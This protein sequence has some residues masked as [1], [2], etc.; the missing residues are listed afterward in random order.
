MIFKIFAAKSEVQSE[1][2]GTYA[3]G[4]F[5]SQRIDVS[6]RRDGRYRSSHERDYGPGRKVAE[7]PL[8]LA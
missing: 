1:D 6:T 8:G 3:D 2:T 4:L 7:M 5:D